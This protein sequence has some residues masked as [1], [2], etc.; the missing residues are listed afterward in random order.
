MMAATCA[1]GVQARRED[2]TK[3]W[4]PGGHLVKHI[5][6][7]PVV[8]GNPESGVFCGNYELDGTIP[9]FWKKFPH[10]KHVNLS[11]NKLR[12]TI[13]EELGD[14]TDLDELWLQGNKLTGTIP[15]SL[16]K[17]TRVQQIHLND[18]QLTGTIPVQKLP[19]K[20]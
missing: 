17:L 11:G 4:R 12:G 18:N 1:I 6:Y 2:I 16:G 7:R 15:A 9:P 5:C 3:E 13:P 8:S 20:L 19:L 10:M 14:L